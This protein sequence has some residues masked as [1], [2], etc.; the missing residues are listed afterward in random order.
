MALRQS[1]PAESR[2][3]YLN[4]REIPL[5]EHEKKSAPI[6]SWPSPALS[7]VAD[8][9]ANDDNAHFQ[10]EKDKRYHQHV[11]RTFSVGRTRIGL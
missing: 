5:A 7:L 8:V 10:P 9:F 1:F 2:R 11:S 6:H 4:R 3:A